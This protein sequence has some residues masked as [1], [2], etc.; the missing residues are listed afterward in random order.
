LIACSRRFVM[1]TPHPYPSARAS[2]LSPILLGLA[3]HCGTKND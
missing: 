1:G 3:R 2:F